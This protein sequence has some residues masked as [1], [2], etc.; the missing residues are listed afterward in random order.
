VTGSAIDQEVVT[1]PIE[2]LLVYV[3][4]PDACEDSP[5]RKAAW[6]EIKRRIQG[7][8]KLLHET[9]ALLLAR[10]NNTEDAMG[11]FIPQA[12]YDSLYQ[13]KLLT[14]GSDITG[15]SWAMTTPEGDAYLRAALESG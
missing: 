10:S 1:A 2:R 7:N 12:T 4:S 5:E 8:R 3:A 14:L 11:E 9:A 6:D 13:R 15:E